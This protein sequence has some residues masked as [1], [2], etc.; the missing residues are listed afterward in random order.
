[1]DHKCITIGPGLVVAQH[2]ASVAGEGVTYCKD[3]DTPAVPA[4]TLKMMTA[5]VARTVVTDAMLGDRVTFTGQVYD[6]GQ[7]APALRVGDEVTFLDLLYGM[8]LPSHNGMARLLAHEVGRIL[9]PAA[10]DPVA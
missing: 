5:Y 1:M 4:S 7:V 10:T 9:D 2:A 6:A 3:P 8:M